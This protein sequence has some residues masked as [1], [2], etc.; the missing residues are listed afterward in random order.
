MSRIHEALKRAE[1]ERGLG[2]HVQ[3]SSTVAVQAPLAPFPADDRAAVRA[4]EP[5][6]ALLAHCAAPVWT[7]QPHIAALFST[8]GPQAGTEELRTLRSRLNQIRDKQLLKTVLITSAMPGEGKTFLTACLARMM[9]RQ[10]GKKVLTIDAD[11]RRPQLDA[12]FGAPSA[13][14][15]T[16]YLTG[17]A[18]ESA[19]LQRGMDPNLYFIPG[20][21]HASNAA[22][23]VSSPRLP[24]LLRRM[25]SLFDWILLDS[26]PVVPVHDAS[27]LSAH[28]HGVLLVVRS[29]ST[30]YDLAQRAATE[31]KNH[32]LLG[33]ILNH[34]EEG[35]SYQSYYYYYGQRDT[36]GTADH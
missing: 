7:P 20:G 3:D 36:G 24:Q 21:K 18:D 14:G 35:Q 32:G 11:L 27:V 1:Q 6:D 28:C 19:V 9:V 16:D 29:A 22:E 25:E 34:V 15:L 30:A 33:V 12:A 13:P 17:A 5:A 31:L 26:P 10:Q 8:A 23:L 2:R 4:P